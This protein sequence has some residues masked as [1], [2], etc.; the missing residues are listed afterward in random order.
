MIGLAQG[1]TFE[2]ENASTTWVIDHNLGRAVCVD[3]VVQ[4]DGKFEKLLPLSISHSNDFNTT[5]VKHSIPLK[6][7][8]RLV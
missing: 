8:A 3:V 7:Q 4:Y 2:F 6:G 1:L 5:I